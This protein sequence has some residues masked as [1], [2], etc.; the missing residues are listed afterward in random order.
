MARRSAFQLRSSAEVAA[1][2]AADTGLPVGA[3]SGLFVSGRI[4]F[5]WLD[6]LTTLV[7]TAAVKQSS[8]FYYNVDALPLVD[9][10]AGVARGASFNMSAESNGIATKPPVAAERSSM[11]DDAA[12]MI[13][14]TETLAPTTL[15]FTSKSALSEAAPWSGFERLVQAAAGDL[16]SIEMVDVM[17]A[18]FVTPGADPFGLTSFMLIDADGDGVDDF[19][20]RLDATGPVL[21]GTDFLI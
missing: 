14:G 10:V 15:S 21:L 6:A 2:L 4:E 8:V 5:G 18:S 17:G 9:S 13:D 3:G 11:G 20:I 1:S 7:D 12:A 16:R 19:V